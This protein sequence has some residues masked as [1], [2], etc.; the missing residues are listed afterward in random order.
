ML[1]L[2]EGGGTDQ[3]KVVNDVRVEGEF[4]APDRHRVT[5]SRASGDTETTTELVAIGSAAW[6]RHDGG[7]W[8]SVTGAID[9]AVP[10]LAATSA[11]NPA[12]L[13]DDRI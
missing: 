4:V 2:P 13:S 11:L 10:G 12:F 8:Q 9:T 7:P 1:E 5:R 3:P 6:V